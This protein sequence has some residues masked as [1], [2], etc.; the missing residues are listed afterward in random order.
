MSTPSFV[1]VTKSFDN[2]C[3]VTIIVKGCRVG[4]K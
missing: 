3:I 2:T 1:S 4:N